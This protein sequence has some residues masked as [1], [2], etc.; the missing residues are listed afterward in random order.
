MQ[1]IGQ[2]MVSL[3]LAVT[4][5][6]HP[7]RGWAAQIFAPQS[8]ARSTQPSVPLPY[9]PSDPPRCDVRLTG[10]IVR[11]DAERFANVV[12]RLIEVRRG[13]AIYACLNSDGG[14]V[15]EAIQIARYIRWL[16]RGPRQKALLSVGSDS[17]IITVVED[18]ARCG[19]ACALVFMAGSL[20]SR[21]ARFLHPRGE[22][23]FHSSFIRIGDEELDKLRMDPDELAQEIKQLYSH[24]LQDFRDIISTFEAV[25]T[26]GGQ[27]PW[28]KSSL[29]LEAFSQDPAELLCVDTIDQVGHWNIQLYGIALPKERTKPMIRN[30]CENT[31]Y[32]QQDRSALVA[33]DSPNDGELPVFWSDPEQEIAGRNAWSAG[34]DLRAKFISRYNYAQ[35]IVEMSGD[36]QVNV[37]YAD[38]SSRRVTEVFDTPPFAFYPP[39]T[40]LQETSADKAAATAPS[41]GDAGGAPR[42]TTRFRE[43]AN[44]TISG[45]T[46]QRLRDSNVDYCRAACDRI[47]ECT[48]YSFNK[49]SRLCELKHTLNAMRHDSLWVSGIP[50]ATGAKEI[51]WSTRPI[52]MDRPAPDPPGTYQARDLAGEKEA[53]WHAPSRGQCDNRCDNDRQCEGYSFYRDSPTA[54]GGRCVLFSRIDDVIAGNADSALKRQR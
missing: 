48:A 37:F 47:A 54:D 3:A 10:E 34:F 22:L 44:S 30:A 32:W 19:S 38:S 46:S 14:S 9:A 41:E 7:E 39:D 52:V 53:E 42:A 27:P 50:S 20:L 15:R 45:C 31:F 28:V 49:I 36:A 11:G 8:V 13:Q 16:G 1:T 6:A 29:F 25:A 12:D 51:H 21:P 33:S 4:V 43:V 18:R 24:G 26:P 17:P 23:V 35:C 40:V 2:I 5:I